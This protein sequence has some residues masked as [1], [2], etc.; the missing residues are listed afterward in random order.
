MDCRLLAYPLSPIFS[1]CP[2]KL[3]LPLKRILKLTKGSTSLARGEELEEARRRR[4]LLPFLLAYHS[5]LGEVDDE[6][7]YDDDEDDEDDVN[8]ENMGP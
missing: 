7:V 6:D 1:S 3:T 4:W 2:P 8:N 5:Q